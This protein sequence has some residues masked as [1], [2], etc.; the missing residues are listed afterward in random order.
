M[1]EQPATDDPQQAEPQPGGMEAYQ[2]RSRKHAW[3]HEAMQGVTKVDWVLYALTIYPSTFLLQF[4]TTPVA[5]LVHYPR[6]RRIA[7]LVLLGIE[8]AVVAFALDRW[9][10]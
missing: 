10:F 4:S 2:R 7:M 9:V 5:R 1:D 6:G 3:Q 8:V